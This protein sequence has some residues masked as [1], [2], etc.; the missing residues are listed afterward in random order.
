MVLLSGNNT[1]TKTK[2]PLI[3][4]ISSTHIEVLVKLPKYDD[5]WN[6][7]IVLGFGDHTISEHSSKTLEVSHV[8]LLV[9]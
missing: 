8:W 7:V 6:F 1:K 4:T 2:E 9:C 5:Y 3:E